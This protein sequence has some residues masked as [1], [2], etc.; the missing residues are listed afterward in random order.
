MRTILVMTIAG[1]LVGVGATAAGAES[2]AGAR[3][4]TE[5]SAPHQLCHR[6]RYGDR[7]RHRRPS[8]E[9]GPTY[10]DAPVAASPRWSDV[11]LPEYMTGDYSNYF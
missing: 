3:C 1:V 5:L 6:Q 2:R 4:A 11:G 9:A 8:I 10:P 7:E